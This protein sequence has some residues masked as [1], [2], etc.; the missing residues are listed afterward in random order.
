M[1]TATKD[2]L[3]VGC[4]LASLCASLA[5]PFITSALSAWRRR[6]DYGRSLRKESYAEI[7]SMTARAGERFISASIRQKLYRQRPESMEISAHVDEDLSAG[8][9]ALDALR[10]KLHADHLLCSDKIIAMVTEADKH[11]WSSESLFRIH[12]H[13]AVDI[14]DLSAR[15]QSFLV[16]LKQRCRREI[17]LR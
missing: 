6:A 10:N 11:L 14:D 12:G 4:S 1:D 7:V 3:V 5:V 15:M 8:W 2:W 13:M 17:G 16:K 9:Q